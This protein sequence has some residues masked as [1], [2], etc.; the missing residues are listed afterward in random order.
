M[1]T[2]TGFGVQWSS[3][4]HRLLM[5]SVTENGVHKCDVA[6]ELSQS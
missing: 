5:N 2:G 3:R 1:T 4:A 6:L